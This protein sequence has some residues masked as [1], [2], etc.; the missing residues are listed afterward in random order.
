MI[1]LDTH[2]WIW[3]VSEPEK[4]SRKALAAINY[5]KQIGICPISCW[6]IATKAAHGKLAFDRDIRVWMS[7]ALALPKFSLVELSAEIA[8]T[9]G[10]LGQRGFRGDPADRLIAATAIQHG[11]ELVSKDGRMRAFEG[12]RTIW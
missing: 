9:A 6:E 8:I 2:A 11:S 5:A 12:V 4:L 7:Q 3:L 1:L 10:Y